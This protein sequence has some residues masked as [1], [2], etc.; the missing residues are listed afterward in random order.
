MSMFC[1]FLLFTSMNMCMANNFCFLL[2]N[3]CN[4]SFVYVMCVEL[5]V[6]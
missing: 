4:L 5:F 2:L 1:C 3:L 6:L